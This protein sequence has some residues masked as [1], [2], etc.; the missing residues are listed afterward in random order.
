MLN[1]NFNIINVQTHTNFPFHKCIRA[2]FM[3]KMSKT[4][5]VNFPRCKN[6]WI[7]KFDIRVGIIN[8]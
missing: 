3:M 4:W 2:F 8:R 7:M 1:L 5:D 6:G